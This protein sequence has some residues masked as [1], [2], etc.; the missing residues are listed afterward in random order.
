MRN[1][2]RLIRELLLVSVNNAIAANRVIIDQAT[3]LTI[4]FGGLVIQAQLPDAD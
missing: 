3:E 2:Q 1:K 4:E